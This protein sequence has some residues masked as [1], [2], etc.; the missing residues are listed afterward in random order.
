MLIA[1]VSVLTANKPPLKPIN[2]APAL[3]KFG[4]SI[5]S[6]KMTNVNA[7]K[8]SNRPTEA[9]RYALYPRLNQRAERE[10]AVNDPQAIKAVRKL[11]ADTS[12]FKISPP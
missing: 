6:E 12:S 10:N 1:M 5:G 2:K 8:P 9:I 3:N 11:V 7:I 4:E